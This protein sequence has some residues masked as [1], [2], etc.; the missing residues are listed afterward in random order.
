MVAFDHCTEIR[1]SVI[2]HA[3]DSSGMLNLT[4]AVM[5]SSDRKH[6]GRAKPADALELA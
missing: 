2:K 6:D 4:E 3:E 1:S 5:F